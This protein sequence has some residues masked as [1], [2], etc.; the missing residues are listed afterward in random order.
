MSGMK[1][2]NWLMPSRSNKA[3][4]EGKAV[5]A[6]RDAEIAELEKARKSA[7]YL[8]EKYLEYLEAC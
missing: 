7:A 4:T 6:L 8:I 5:G 3:G 2:E 1:L